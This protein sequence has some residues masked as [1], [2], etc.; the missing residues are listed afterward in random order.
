MMHQLRGHMWLPESSLRARASSTNFVKHGADVYMPHWLPSRLHFHLHV[1]LLQHLRTSTQVYSDESPLISQAMHSSTV[2]VLLLALAAGQSAVAAPIQSTPVQARDAELDARTVHLLAPLIE[3]LQN[4]VVGGLNPRDLQALYERGL[5]GDIEK[6]GGKVI[7]HFFSG[8]S[9]DDNDDSSAPQ[10]AAGQQGQATRRALAEL[11]ERELDERSFASAISSI[12]S[13]IPKFL[14]HLAAGA[15]GAGIAG[16]FFGGSHS[17]P[18]PD[19]PA[20]TA[21][22]P[23]DAPTA[24][25]GTAAPAER[26]V[27]EY[28]AKRGVL[29]DYLANELSGRS[30]ASAIEEAGKF[31]ESDIGKIATKFAG[32]IGSGIFSGIGSQQAAPP[33][34]IVQAPAPAKSAAAPSATSAPAA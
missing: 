21:T 6:L 11:L 27:V 8:G 10:P 34:V 13:K 7:G 9:S 26:D 2:A 24:V 30:L 22:A 15:V 23:V 29:E 28:L 12:A 17:S 16:S 5:F 1:T 20:P 25:G 3:N 32:H 31:A 19:A 33:T 14:P 18:A 4:S